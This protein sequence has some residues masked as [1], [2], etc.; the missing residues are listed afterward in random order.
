MKSLLLF[1]FLIAI[2]TNTS[3]SQL[4]N[5]G[6]YLLKNLD[7]AGRSYSAC[8]GY[9]APNGREYALL[10]FNGGTAFID[11]TDS[12]NIREVDV[13]T[14]LSSGWREMKTYSHYAYIV[15][16][17]TNSQLQIVDLQYLPDS[18]S[19]VR[20][21][22]YTGYTKTHSISQS[23]PYLY[24]NGG[25]ASPNGGVAI[26]DVSNPIE[27]VKKGQ[28]TTRY[29]HDCRVLN[30]TIWAA[31]ISDQKVTVINATNKD[32]LQE[33]TNW[34]NLP[35]PSP[36]NAAITKDRKYI[37]VTDE[38]Q[39]PGKLKVWN[40]QNLSNITFVTQWQPTGI[41]TAI[42][43]NVEIY[44]DFAVIAHY[45]AGI[46]IVNISNPASP[47]EVAWYDTRPSDN[48]NA[49]SGCWGVYK[50]PS[51]KIIG[52]DM[53]NG[54]FVIKTTFPLT[55]I[56]ENSIVKDYIL[57]QN[58]PNPFNPSTSIKFSIKS[59]SVVSLKIHNVNGKEVASVINDRRDAGQY[60]VNIN[61]N[62]FNLSSG[63]YFY[64][65]KVVSG[66]NKFSETKKM[67][68]VK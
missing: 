28:W 43:H 16:E 65:L 3:F 34:N 59:S 56:H 39:S 7:V 60:E 67:I 63:T 49:Y 54:L 36:H 9:T 68:L 10:G 58:F 2:Y 57:E 29:V 64:T 21:W 55:N 37:L 19:L 20:T 33:I 13:V 4:P 15:S 47:L 23:G 40:I 44:G 45:S 25:N 53:S 46:R 41:T 48:A 42:V 61:V 17:A 14:G 35:S 32:N 51:G 24:L 27:P 52:S 1:I 62:D 66:F 18:V 8:W 11:I 22:G 26:I 31:N 5:Q 30:D 6:T 12:A 38:N 50:F